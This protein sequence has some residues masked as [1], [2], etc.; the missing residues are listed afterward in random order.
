MIGVGVILDCKKNKGAIESIN[1]KA[2]YK[3]ERKKTHIKK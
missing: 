3:N 1:R 2:D